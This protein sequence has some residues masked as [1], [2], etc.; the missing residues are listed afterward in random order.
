MQVNLQRSRNAAD[1]VHGET[2]IGLNIIGAFAVRL[3]LLCANGRG[4]TLLRYGHFNARV[5]DLNV[6]FAVEAPQ[7]LGS[8]RNLLHDVELGCIRGA[9]GSTAGYKRYPMIVSLKG[10]LP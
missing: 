9:S 6:P 5:I 1:V 2:A 7:T 8:Y 10:N 4:L 3:P